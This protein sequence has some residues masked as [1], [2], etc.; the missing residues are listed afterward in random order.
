MALGQSFPT[1][2]PAIASILTTSQCFWINLPVGGVAAIVTF[3][4]FKPNKAAKP[5]QAT[6]TEVILQLDLVG[7][8]LM[9]SLLTCYILALQ[10]G[11]QTYPWKSAT[12]IGLLAGF[13]L[14]LAAFVAWELFQKE[15]A[16]IVP[17]I[18][19]LS[20]LFINRNCC[21]CALTGSPSSQ[22]ATSGRALS[23][24]SSSRAP[25]LSSCT[26]FRSTFRPS[27]MQTP[28]ARASVCWP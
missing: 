12:V 27:T 3:F 25:T 23:S 13:I 5:V 4:S 18:V 9:I 8:A 6:W 20:L 11:G 26:T 21:E 7:A 17:R 2:P 16:M 10:Y 22:S 24:W 15:Y 14:L 1:S 28:S 19:S